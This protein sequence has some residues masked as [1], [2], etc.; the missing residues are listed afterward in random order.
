M[1]TEAAFNDA[2]G[3]TIFTVVITSFAL[4]GQSLVR[5][6]INFG[7]ILGGGVFIGFVI[8]LVADFLSRLVSDPLS[9]TM[10]TIT[11]V[12][13]SYTVAE[14]F[15]VSGLISVAVAGLV[16][17]NLTMKRRVQPQSTKVVR[18]FWRIMAFI[19]NSLAF[20]YIGLST[21]L[22]RLV[23]DLLPIGYA[24]F[25]VLIARIAT[26]YP[27]LGASRV[28]GQPI[29]RT[30]QNVAVLGGMKGALSIV[31]A[32]SLPATTPARDLI[33]SMVLGVAFASIVI[34]GVLLSRYTNSK[35]TRPLRRNK[36]HTGPQEITVQTPTSGNNSPTV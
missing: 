17:G 36:I 8:A 24:F 12:Y 14:L 3:I 34:Q 16:Y 19:A 27:L 6:T 28:D 11:L 9:E 5:S 35:F 1:D 29:P 32:A 22:A 10:I 7:F 26:V 20:L 2:T 31:L 13:G 23:A 18:I 30:W 15:G 21:N 4:T 33:S 25:A